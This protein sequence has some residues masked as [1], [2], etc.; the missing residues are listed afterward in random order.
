MPPR[1]DRRQDAAACARAICRVRVRQPWVLSSYRTILVGHFLRIARSGFSRTVIRSS[2][3]NPSRRRPRSRIR[4]TAESAPRSDPC[5]FSSLFDL[6]PDG[7]SRARKLPRH[8][9]FVLL[10]Q[11][12]GLRERQ[13]LPV[14]PCRAASRSRGSRRAIARPSAV[15]SK[16]NQP[17]DNQGRPRVKMTAGS[18]ISS[19]SESMD[20]D[21]RARD[22]CA[23][24]REPH[25]AMSRG[26]CGHE[27]TGAATVACLTPLVHAVKIGVQGIGQLARGAG[28][29]E[30]SAARYRCWPHL[31]DEMIPCVSMPLRTGARE[32]EIFQMKR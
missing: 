25:A 7:P 5:A 18:S 16:C 19:G 8:R 24:A 22:R 13:L 6:C 9:R 31:E 3:P 14:V 21:G 30:A 15:R 11:A 1:A 32:R 29:I 27:N 28:T 23:A 17:R 10:E 26:C 20:G 4:N 2:P 12:A